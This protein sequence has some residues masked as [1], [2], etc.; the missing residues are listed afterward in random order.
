MKKHY[1]F[2]LLFFPV[3]LIAQILPITSTA[4]LDLSLYGEA[5]TYPGQGEYEIFLSA[6]TI[7][8]KPIFIVDQFDPGD[9]IDIPGIYSLLDFSGTAGDQNLADILRAEGFDIVL[10][11]FPTYTRTEDAVTVD[12][13]A[14]FIER[15]AMILVELIELINT[16][17][18][19]N[20][21]DQ[22]VIIGLSMGGIIARYALNYMENQSLDADTRLYISFDSPH[23]G[24]NIPIGL[25]HQLN[26]LAFN[27][28]NPITEVQPLI[29]GLLKSPATKQ[30]LTDHLEAHL[31]GADL[32][33]FDPALT[34]P[35]AHPFRGF[36]ESNIN[37][38]T[39]SGFP[40]NVR[41]VAVINGSGIGTPY[42]ALENSGP[43][44]GNDY[45]VINTDFGVPAGPFTAT[46]GVTINLTPGAGDTSTVS[47][48]SI[49]LFGA[50][51][52]GS[53]A[54][55]Q[56]F[57]F[58][59]GIDAAPGGLFDLAGLTDGIA[60]GGG[61]AADFVNALTIDKF[62]FVPA[63]SALALEI[64]DNEIDWHHTIDLVGRATTNNTPFDNS[65]LPDNNEPHLQLS[66]ANVD[67]VLLEIRTPPLSLLNENAT[68]FQLEKN[69]VKDQLVLLS[70]ANINANISIT[71]LTGKIVFNSN[72]NLS[73]RT[74]IP[75]NLASG[76]YIL[77]ISDKNNARFATKIAV[78]K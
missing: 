76:F 33:T 60:A 77:N 46:I 49:Q 42:F 70:N 5:T 48:I 7:L 16:E 10:L 26:W 3:L 9:T 55:S 15:N 66:Q 34:L 69:P 30:L 47:D 11:N 68:L 21:S 37:S 65:F 59:D 22:N 18:A 24:A 38:L 51:I 71:D 32:V 50:E 40:E 75:L 8:D 78:H 20:S 67:F 53:V 6:D 44:V 36:F 29:T 62:S 28:T 1:V 73:N 56:S 72:L 23:H 4:P 31:S 14:D 2:I 45:P 35:Q 43:T 41:N 12:G 63:V 25:Q 39:A 52:D 61:I 58:S 27:G 64:T 54:E 17:K 13:G 74:S 57:P 19:A